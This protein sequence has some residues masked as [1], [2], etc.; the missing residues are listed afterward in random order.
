[1]SR[2]RVTNSKVRTRLK[3]LPTQRT[4]ASQD[5]IK[6]IHYKLKLNDI[7]FPT[8]LRFMYEMV[9]TKLTVLRGILKL[10]NTLRLSGLTGPEITF[11]TGCKCNCSV[12]ESSKIV[13]TIMTEKD[14]M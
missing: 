2:T 7:A 8:S 5:A 12:C 13:L 9:K 11:K 3:L 6:I 4:D 14:E 1:M 10:L